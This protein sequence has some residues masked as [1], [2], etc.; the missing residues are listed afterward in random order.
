VWDA[1]GSGTISDTELR[2]MVRVYPARIDL[3]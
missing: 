1:D 3:P 2:E